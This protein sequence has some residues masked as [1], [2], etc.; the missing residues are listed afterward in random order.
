MIAAERGM[1]AYLSFSFE[2]TVFVQLLCKAL[3]AEK[4]PYLASSA[5]SVGRLGSGSRPKMW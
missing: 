3:G 4:I 5:E 1:P 2:N